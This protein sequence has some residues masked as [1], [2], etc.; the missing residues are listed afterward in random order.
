MTRSSATEAF[1]AS[2]G[3]EPEFL[4]RAPGR[5]NLI[6]E[7]VDYNDG[8]VLPMA[9]DLGIWVACGSRSDDRI[10]YVAHDLG[11]LRDG[12][13]R[14]E[15]VQR[16]NDWR[17]H[18]RGVAA[19][20]STQISSIPSLSLAI[21]GNLPSGRGLSSSAALG[22]AIARAL[23]HAA[24]TELSAQR[25]ALLAQWAERDFVGTQCGIMDQLA[26]AVG[27]AGHVLKLD[28]R[29]LEHALVKWPTN[30]AV[31]VVD[32]GI[33]RS[34]ADSAFNDRT[35]ACA[36]AAERMGKTSLRDASLAD[37]AGHRSQLTQEET[38]LAHHVVSEIARTRDAASAIRRKDL[39]E[40]GALMRASHTSLRDDFRVSLPPIDSL[41]SLQ[42][43]A[44]G[45]NGGARMMGG[46]F[47]GCTVAVCGHEDLPHLQHV[48]T[49]G[50]RTPDGKKA[51]M[52]RAKPS[53]GAEVV[54]ILGGRTG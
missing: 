47:G 37:I 45:E 7:H 28:C 29:T 50:Y 1:R 39:F 19:A 12:F 40:I 33:R 25:I 54:P 49:A 36:M 51:W 24:Q 30:W 43:E 8:I 9:I 31:L 3:V 48:V 6:G 35:K 27:S 46:G 34:L 15:E 10:E 42:N 52:Y 4:V 32:S 14:A 38:R 2:F 41:V 16:C 5:V 23:D 11:G 20:F 18:V 53:N 26:S 13:C 17:D 21:S 44:L 22:V